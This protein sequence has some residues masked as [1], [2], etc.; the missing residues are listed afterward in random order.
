MYKII[1]AVSR[2]DSLKSEYLFKVFSLLGVVQ[3]VFPEDALFTWLE[4]EAERK[5]NIRRNPDRDVL[6][7]LMEDENLI[8]A[9]E[10]PEEAKLREVAL[11]REQSLCPPQ[12]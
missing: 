1:V 11:L 12:A 6:V 3:A 10:D 4:I 8:W 9:A 2:R 7:V 5:F